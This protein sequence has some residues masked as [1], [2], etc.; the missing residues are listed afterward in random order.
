MTSLPSGSADIFGASTLQ[1][2]QSEDKRTVMA[3]FFKDNAAA[4]RKGGA[5]A[6]KTRRQVED[7]NGQPVVTPRN[8]IDRSEADY[9]LEDASEQGDPEDDVPF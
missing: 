2:H 1:L 3:R 6:G 8:F 5:V 9:L 7:L 4:A